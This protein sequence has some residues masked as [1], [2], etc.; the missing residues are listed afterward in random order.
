M[1]GDGLTWEN[2]LKGGVGGA[3]AG[4]GLGFM[5]AKKL[6]LTWAQG[7]LGGAVI[8]L[9]VALLIESV[10]DIITRGLNIGTSILGAIGGAIAGAAAGFLYMGGSGGAILGATIGLGIALVIE[11]IADIAVSGSSLANGAIGLIG[12]ALAGAGLG[13]YLG[14][15]GG[16][17]LGA[18]VGVGLTLSFESVVSP[19]AGGVNLFDAIKTVM[20]E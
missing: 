5:L 6:G 17:V 13:F 1:F 4:A 8:G 10:A 14:G 11:S 2:I 18:I 15:P 9:C 20:E 16:S 7:M 12:G 19:I 3:L